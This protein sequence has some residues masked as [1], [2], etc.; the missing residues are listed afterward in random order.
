MYLVEVDFYSTVYYHHDRDL[1]FLACHI[2]KYEGNISS[3]I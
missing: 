3:H 1:W 2:N